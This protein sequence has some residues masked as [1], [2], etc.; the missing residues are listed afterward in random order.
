VDVNISTIAAT[1]ALQFLVKELAAPGSQ[2]RAYLLQALK[3]AMSAAAENEPKAS[4][5][6]DQPSPTAEQVQEV[7]KQALDLLADQRLV[8]RQEAGGGESVYTITADG[9]KEV[10]KSSQKGVSRLLANRL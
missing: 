2:L 9:V 1:S 10:E 5:T 8:R 3:K 6:T 4:Q 7:I